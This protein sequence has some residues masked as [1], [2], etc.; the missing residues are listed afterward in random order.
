[1][2]IEAVARLDLAKDH[3][4]PLH[5]VGGSH[6]FVRA[7]VVAWWRRGAQGSLVP[8]VVALLL[9][10]ELEEQVLRAFTLLA[11]AI[12]LHAQVLQLFLLLGLEL[13]APFFE[14]G[15]VQLTHAPMSQVKMCSL[16]SGGLA[17]HARLWAC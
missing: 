3:I 9:V 8:A 11:F 5:V 16:P 15:E 12:D 1:M 10:T 14:H 4:I 13:R 7:L 17:R 2:S 6:R